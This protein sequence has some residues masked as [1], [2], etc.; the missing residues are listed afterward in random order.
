MARPGMAV[1]MC[2]EQCFDCL[3]GVLSIAVLAHDSPVAL[4]LNVY[5]VRG[6]AEYR[7][8]TKQPKVQSTICTDVLRTSDGIES[9]S[10]QARAGAVARHTRC[11]FNLTSHYQS[12][13][14]PVSCMRR[15]R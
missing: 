6:N 14:K 4:D 10:A 3:G 5:M 7:L 15:L 2:W 1:D 9:S 8:P 13:E 11:R 12:I